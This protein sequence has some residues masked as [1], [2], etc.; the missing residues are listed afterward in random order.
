MAAATSHEVES[1]VIAVQL[2]RQYVIDVL[3][4]AG[5]PE[6]A[7]EALHE[8]PDPELVSMWAISSLK[9]VIGTPLRAAC[10]SIRSPRW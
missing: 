4:T 2:T 3:R 5:L 7:D 10:R 6:M 8:L 9:P 1:S